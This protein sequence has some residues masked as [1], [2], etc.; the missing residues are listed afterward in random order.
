MVIKMVF[1]SIRQAAK[2]YELGEDGHQ[3]TDQRCSESF[4]GGLREML[5]SDNWYRNRVWSPR[6][7]VPFYLMCPGRTPLLGNCT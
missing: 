2:I 5:R 3:S 7:K 1:R 4:N 6:T